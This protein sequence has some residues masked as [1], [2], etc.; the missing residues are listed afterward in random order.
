MKREPT[1]TPAEEEIIGHIADG[2]SCT[3]IA[4]WL[5]IS[6]S[7]VYVHL[8]HI[9]AKLP[10]DDDLK[11]YPLVFLWAAHRKWLLKHPPPHDN[12]A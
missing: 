4:G 11:P 3:R 2:W 10:N 7:T 9:A 1:F 8:N 12:A 5:G 6:T